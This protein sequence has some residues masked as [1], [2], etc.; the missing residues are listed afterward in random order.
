[1]SVFALLLT[2][3]TAYYAWASTSIPYSIIITGAQGGIDCMP[4][5]DIQYYGEGKMS[6]TDH[7]QD[8]LDPFQPMFNFAHNLHNVSINGILLDEVGGIHNSW[9]SVACYCCDCKWYCIYATVD[10]N[11]HQIEL[12]IVHDPNTLCTSPGGCNPN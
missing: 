6:E 1:M 4:I 3:S 9:Q 12:Q 11:N 10:E 5:L 7:F 2:T 8:Q